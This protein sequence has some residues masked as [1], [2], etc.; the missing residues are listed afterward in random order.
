MKYRRIVVECKPDKELINWIFNIIN[1]RM[2][3]I[4]RVYKG[5]K[6]AVMDIIKTSD[7][8]IAVVDED[9]DAPRH[10]LYSKLTTIYN[11]NYL[12]IYGGIHNN[13]VFELRPNLE[14]WLLAIIR[15]THMKIGY[16]KDEKYLHARLSARPRQIITILEKARKKSKIL[17]EFITNFK[18]YI[19]P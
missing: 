8:V 13:I 11:S 1:V 12:N 6:G 16:P 9:P 14:G 5:G 17:L 15:E 4:H 18:K 7:H 2:K 3:I 10:P 19:S